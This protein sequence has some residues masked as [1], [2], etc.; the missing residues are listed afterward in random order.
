MLYSNRIALITSETEMQQNVQNLV[1]SYCGT[2]LPI[3]LRHALAVYIYTDN[4]LTT[5]SKYE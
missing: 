3:A 1:Y 2:L 5:E 4:A